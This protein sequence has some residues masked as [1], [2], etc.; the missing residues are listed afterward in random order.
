MQE[1]SSYLSQITKKLLK[2]EKNLDLLQNKVEKMSQDSKEEY[3]IVLDELKLKK[4]Q[5]D[6]TLKETESVV[7]ENWIETRERIDTTYSEFIK[8]VGRAI[9]KF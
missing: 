2:W 1:K 9:E 5:V 7:S 6:A 3:Q 4:E 8:A